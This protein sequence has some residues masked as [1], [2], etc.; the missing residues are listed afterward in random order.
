V[1]LQ[2]GNYGFHN[3]YMASAAA[4]YPERLTA[5]GAIDP[6]ALYA[7]KI[8]D[9]LVSRYNFR[10]IKFELSSEWGLSGYHADL[11]MND[12]AFARLLKKADELGMTVAI[13]MGMKHMPSFDLEAFKELTETYKNVLF[14]MAHSF[15]PRNDGQNEERLALARSLTADNFVMD[16]ANVDV[17]A[18]AEYLKELKSIIGAERM[19]WGTDLPGI[20]CRMSYKQLIDR[21]YES[22][23]FTK[24]ELPLVMG[25]NAE[26]VYLK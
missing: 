11:R 22:G 26:R 17:I 21:V 8:F 1:L 9:N 19:M 10:S 6:Y 5:V 7:D 25:E 23:V 3:D 4:R 20:L 2:G 24:S 15:F 16:F 14:V 18:Q 13:D 12:E